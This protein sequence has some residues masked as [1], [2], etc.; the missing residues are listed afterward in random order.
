MMNASRKLPKLPSILL[1][2]AQAIWITPLAELLHAPLPKIDTMQQT[3]IP[4]RGL[5]LFPNSTGGLVKDI[6]FPG[7]R[8]CC[9]TYADCLSAAINPCVSFRKLV[10]SVSNRF[11]CMD[12]SC[13]PMWSLQCG[14]GLLNLGVDRSR[15]TVCF[16]GNLEKKKRKCRSPSFKNLPFSLLVTEGNEE[17]MDK[18][19]RTDSMKWKQR[20]HSGGVSSGSV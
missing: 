6:T 11:I 5:P 18:R 12:V 19:N 3:V 20:A 9:A 17:D 7:S 8:L 10:H 2:K 4:L 15:A 16:S 1:C 14:E 13:K